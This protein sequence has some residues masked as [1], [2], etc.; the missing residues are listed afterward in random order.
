MALSRSAIL[1]AFGL[2]AFWAVLA[3]AQSPDEALRKYYDEGERA[4]AQNHYAEAERAYEKLRELSPQTAEIHARLGLV[5]FQE[6][7]FDQ[8]VPTLRQALKLKPGLPKL[9][10]L[11]AMSLS[12]LGQYQEAMPGLE[13]GFKSSDPAIKRMCG[14]QLLRADTGLQRDN[15]AVEVALELNHAYP[16][17]PEVLYHTSKIY[18]NFAFLT[19]EKL[20]Q[21]APDSVWR[22]QAAGEAYESQGSNDLAISEYRQVLAIDPRRPGIHFRLGRTL[23]ARARQNNSTDKSEAMKEFEQELQLDPSNGNAAYEMAQIHRDAGEL[24]EAQK[25][26]E[27]ALKH[28]PDFEEAHLGIGA[29]L[30]AE[31]KPAEAL[32]HLRKAITLNPQNEVSWYRLGQAQRALGNAAEQQKA[33][34]EFQ[35]VR[36]QNR[37]HGEADQDL[38]SRSEVTRQQVDANPEQ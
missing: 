26:F 7:K 21:A 13:K 36:K 29:T 22:H 1:I 28:Y 20:S 4:L 17:D 10:T 15:K 9:D 37:G 33:F 8:A 32:P 30:I 14:L 11:L 31:H 35:R 34:A 18:G 24:E 3:V 12:E 2:R 25:F 6:K 5:Y 38:F 27:L 16:N 23:L 19:I